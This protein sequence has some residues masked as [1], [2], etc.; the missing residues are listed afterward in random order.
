MLGSSGNCSFPS[1]SDGPRLLA[2]ATPSHS[3]IGSLRRNG[4][5]AGKARKFDSTSNGVV[6]LATYSAVELFLGA[7]PQART[8]LQQ[9]RC[10]ISVISNSALQVRL[11]T[12]AIVE[13][14]STG[15]DFFWRNL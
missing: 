12:P 3:S 14:D 9:R 1:K 13:M 6:C 7:T 8:R 10:L 2:C 15:L 11:H 4:H 5:Y